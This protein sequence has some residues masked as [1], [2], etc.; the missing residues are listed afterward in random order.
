MQYDTTHVLGARIIILIVSLKRIC[1][2][3]HNGPFTYGET[4]PILYK[5]LYTSLR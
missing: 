5:T 3:Y 4:S 2:Y 1:Y